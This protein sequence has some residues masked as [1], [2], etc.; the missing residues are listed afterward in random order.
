MLPEKYREL[1]Y[2]ENAE[3]GSYIDAGLIPS[4]DMKAVIDGYVIEGDTAFFG[5]RRGLQSADAYTLQYTSEKYYRFNFNSS[6]TAAPKTFVPEVRHV[7][8]VSV[9][10]FFIDD[11]EIGVPAPKTLD[12]TFPLYMLGAVNTNGE[13]ASFGLVR[14]YSAKFYRGDILVADFI[15]CVSEEGIIGMYDNVSES[16]FMNAG[17][18]S[19]TGEV[20]PF[21]G[22]RID[23]LPYKTTYQKGEEFEPEGLIV[24]E[25]TRGGYHEEITDYTISGFDSSEIGAKT[26]TVSYGDFTALFTI[27]VE[28]V[29]VS[30]PVV[31][32]E[33]MKQYLRVDFEDDDSLIEYLIK[34]SE[35]R[36]MDIARISDK[37]KFRSLEDAKIAVVFAVAYQ[38]EHREDLNQ[39]D[40][41]LTLRALL[42]AER[43]AGF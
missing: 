6:R 39:N 33:E 1:L 5:S 8:Q 16:F 24:S 37:A 17:T 34:V 7:F 43:E 9:D 23:S 27:V 40:L 19:F 13:A 28:D 30:E 36:C 41:N 12:A 26:I 2:I 10:G 21:I 38:Y 31:T 14:I 20:E 11:T 42:F 3:T 32:V 25:Y 4:A 22:I 29:P 15:P 35:K 18:G